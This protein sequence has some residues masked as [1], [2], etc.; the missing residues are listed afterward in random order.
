MELSLEDIKDELKNYYY[1][2]TI[3][4]EYEKSNGKIEDLYD[5]ATKTTTTISDMP[6]GNS[7][8]MDRA[9]ECVAEMVDLQQENMKLEKEYAVGLMTL[10][11]TNL[12]IHKTIMSLDNPYKTVLIHIYIHNKTREETAEILN[13][14]KR[15]T[16]K[17]IGFGL[18]RYQKERNKNIQ[19]N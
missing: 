19:K 13:R 15:W 6:K 8:V 5:R 2:Q 7:A 9:A 10:K 4:N 14:S 11:N 16:D 1:H 18:L 12:I 3:I 17:L